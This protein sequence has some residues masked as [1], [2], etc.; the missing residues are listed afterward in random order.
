MNYQRFSYLVLLSCLVLSLIG[1]QLQAQ[2]R[3]VPCTDSDGGKNREVQGTVHLGYSSWTDQCWDNLTVKEYFCKN[4]QTVSSVRMLCTAGKK[5]IDGACVVPPPPSCTDSDPDNDLTVQGSVSGIDNSGY[6]RS[7]S[8]QCDWSNTVGTVPI[9]V[10]EY[11]CDA[12]GTH[13]TSSRIDCPIDQHC[14]NGACV[15]GGAGVSCEDSDGGMNP[16]MPGTVTAGA[17]TKKDTLHGDWLTNHTI[18]EYSCREDGFILETVFQCP[19]DNPY[20]PSDD[21]FGNQNG[22]YYCL[23]PPDASDCQNPPQE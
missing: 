10:T 5:C 14:E 3:A 7:Y 12:D 20:V 4:I 17:I 18:S 1:G 11:G 8:D 21:F 22:Q 15:P 16:F 6:P 9:Q 19:T 2:R 23:C 13:I